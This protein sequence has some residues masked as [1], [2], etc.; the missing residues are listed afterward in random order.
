[1][2]YIQIGSGSANLDTNIQDGFAN[3]IISRDIKEELLR[4]VKS[5][6]VNFYYI[7]ANT[8]NINYSM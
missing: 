6:G 5:C 1:M 4:Q 8:L 2:S 3:Y 7:Y